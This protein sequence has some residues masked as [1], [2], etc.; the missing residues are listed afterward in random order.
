M[1]IILYSWQIVQGELDWHISLIIW[2]Q[3]RQKRRWTELKKIII[4][5]AFKCFFE[6]YSW[7]L[8]TIHK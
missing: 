5:S 8:K 6:R 3:K 4:F 2:K 1:Y 7:A